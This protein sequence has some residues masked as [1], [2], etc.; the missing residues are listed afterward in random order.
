MKQHICFFQLNLESGGAERQIIHLLTHW[1]RESAELSLVLIEPD[2][3]WLD[4][5]PGDITVHTLHRK[6]PARLYSRLVWFF[7][8]LMKV[9]RHFKHT[10]YDIVLGFL[11]LPAFLWSLATLF[12]TKRPK[13]VWSAQ[14]NLQLAL[15]R[16]A[17]ERLFSPL[18][19]CVLSAGIDLVIA[20]SEGVKRRTDE[21]L[22][23][24]S[25]T[26]KT[27]VIP[28][29]IDLDQVLAKASDSSGVTPK[30]KPLRVIAVGRL[31]HEKGVDLLLEAAAEL[32]KQNSLFEIAIVGDGQEKEALEKLGDSLNLSNCVT[33]Y[34]FQANPFAWLKS[35][36]V[37][38][39]PSRWETFGIAIAEAMALGLPVVSTRTDGAVAAI[40]D[41]GAGLLVDISFKGLAQALER[42]LTDDS[43]RR[44]LGELASERARQFSAPMNAEAYQ[45][46]LS[47]L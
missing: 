41:D 31:R 16:S 38:V 7:Q 26:S 43:L 21:F 17:L 35:A 8:V 29:A 25:A 10:R 42:V 28:N 15:N 20:P 18:I 47:N 14:T 46:A 9:V 23:H 11:W 33:F 40:G 13:F 24:S 32:K 2:S 44:S 6:R 36:D 27:V 22:G 5:V 19:A 34:G 1:P 37:F 4:E 30:Q 3:L 39:S 45:K 12:I